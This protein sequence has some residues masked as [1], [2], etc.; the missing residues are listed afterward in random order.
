MKGANRHFPTCIGK[1]MYGCLHVFVSVHF[2][3]LLIFRIRK[4]S[5][6]D[7]EKIISISSKFPDANWWLK[8]PTV[9]LFEEVRAEKREGWWCFYLCSHIILPFILRYNSHPLVN[10]KSIMIGIVLPKPFVTDSSIRNEDP[11]WIGR[12]GLVPSWRNAPLLGRFPTEGGWRWWVST[13][14]L[15]E[16]L[17]NRGLVASPKRLITKLAIE[18]LVYFFWTNFVVQE[19]AP[20]KGLQRKTFWRHS[21]KRIN[22]TEPS[23][24][25]SWC[26]EIMCCQTNL[27]LIY[28]MKKFVATNNLGFT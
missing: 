17:Q 20:R 27:L 18:K 8:N 25:P 21:L 7:I 9:W 13:V 10:Y 24:G 4:G 15:L 28:M 14:Q 19:L 5:W 6:L 2:N 23:H 22:S 16:H 26:L 11:S 1:S 12:F 3:Q